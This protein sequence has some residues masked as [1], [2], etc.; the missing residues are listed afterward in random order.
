MTVMD[1]HTGKA[2]IGDD[3]DDQDIAMILTTAIGSRSCRREF[4]SD[5]PRLIDQ[6]FNAA[7][8]QRLLGATAMALMRW[9]PRIKLDRV[10]IL[11]RDQPGAFTVLLDRRR[12]NGTALRSAIA[13]NF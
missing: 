8:R 9:K 3:A 6:P 13:L 12:A 4:G 10:Q 1:A 11:R 5:I 7:T 2:L